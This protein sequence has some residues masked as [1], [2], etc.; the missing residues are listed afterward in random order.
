M[1]HD[2]M[3]APAW[4]VSSP[5]VRRFTL[6]IFVRPDSDPQAR[7]S[8]GRADFSRHARRQSF[9]RSHRPNAICRSSILK[10]STPAIGARLRALDGEVEAA[11]LRR[12]RSSWPSSPS[13]DHRGP[14]QDAVVGSGER[15][16]RR[17]P[18]YALNRAGGDDA[19]LPKYL[20]PETCGPAESK[21]TTHG[22]Q[23]RPVSAS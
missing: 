4:A 10:P 15:H 23:I 6:G 22:L 3:R 19:D 17:R 12:R 14:L 2:S 11:S 20:P 8:E 5:K 7:R 13:Q 16:C 9:Q 21:T 1:G 18:L